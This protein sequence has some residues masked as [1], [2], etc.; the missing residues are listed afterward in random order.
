MREL[1]KEYLEKIKT[2]Y[3]KIE[4]RHR[5]VGN[6]AIVMVYIYLI[7]MVEWL[8][9]GELEDV[10]GITRLA[11]EDFYNIG[12]SSYY[13]EMERLDENTAKVERKQ[14][15]VKVE[16]PECGNAQN[17]PSYMAHGT[18]ICCGCE[19]EFTTSFA[20]NLETFDR[21]TVPK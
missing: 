20:D 12:K 21:S 3:E 4:M 18:R 5:K 13:D 8:L 6:D 9:N 17:L 2:R 16:C 7:E 15:T 1:N 11:N 19:K 10:P 14:E